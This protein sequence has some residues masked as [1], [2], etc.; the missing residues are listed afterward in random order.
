MGVGVG[1]ARRERKRE[2]RKGRNKC[3][4]LNLCCPKSTF[5]CSLDLSICPGVVSKL[6]RNDIL[7]TPLPSFPG[8]P[9][10]PNIPE[11]TSG[12]GDEVLPYLCSLQKKHDSLGSVVVWGVLGHGRSRSLPSPP[13]PSA[14]DELSTPGLA[15][16]GSGPRARCA[17]G[18][19]RSGPP[20]LP[21]G[22]VHRRGARTA[23]GRGDRR[24][25]RPRSATHRTGSGPHAPAHPR[26]PL[27]RP[28]LA[29]AE[30]PERGRPAGAP[31]LLL[32]PAPPPRPAPPAVVCPFPPRLAGGTGAAR[33]NPL[34][35]SATWR[36]TDRRG[37]GA[38]CEPR[39]PRLPSW[40]AWLTGSAAP[41]RELRAVGAGARAARWVRGWRAPRPRGRLLELSGTADLTDSGPGKPRL[42]APARVLR[43]E[44]GGTEA[45]RSVSRRTNRERGAGPGEG[46]GGR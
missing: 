36:R 20:G 37:V 17:P 38:G 11:G 12:R 19:A 9:D 13:V 21:C 32:T 4:R 45:P 15:P 27:Q 26:L 1:E 18:E 14:P 46:A 6:T 22:R 31:T 29:R 5:I 34:P 40:R 44:G 41:G 2:G 42:L 39:G 33:S 3:G 8:H 25:P 16:W 10:A 30:Q 24:A 28:L 7:K 43:R 35:S 23:P